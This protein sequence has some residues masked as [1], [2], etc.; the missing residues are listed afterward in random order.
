MMTVSADDVELHGEQA[1]AVGGEIGRSAGSGSAKSARPV[2]GSSPTAE[3]AAL[4]SAAAIG[5]GSSARSRSTRATVTAT[6]TSPARRIAIGARR[7]AAR[8]RDGAGGAASSGS[9]ARMRSCSSRSPAPGSSPSSSTLWAAAVPIRVER[10]PR[11]PQRYN[12][13]MSWPRS[14]SRSRLAATRDF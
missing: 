6:R 7:A 13:S 2:C 8:G 1:L 12:A 4:C 10:V 14:R 11:R 3:L 5:A 9:S